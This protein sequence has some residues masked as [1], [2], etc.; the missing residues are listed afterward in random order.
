MKSIYYIPLALCFLVSCEQDSNLTT[1][2]TETPVIEA[3]LVGGQ[4][5]DTFKV[6]Q[7]VSY[8]SQDSVVTA[9]D[10]LS[11]FISDGS[12]TTTI[13]LNNIGDGIYQNLDFIIQNAQSYTMSF[14][15]NGEVIAAETYIPA[16]KE[17]AATTTTIYMDKIE[18]NGSFP[19]FG[20]LQQPDPVEL[21]WDNQEGD[22]Y[23]VVVQNIEEDPETINELIQRFTGGRRF[24]FI[25]EPQVMD[26]YA[27]QP[28]REIQQF[29]T[30]Q[31]IVFRVNPEYAAL[32]ETS[33]TTSTTISQ[34]PSNIEN[35]LGIFTG[36]ATDTVFLE[37]V[38]R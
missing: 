8:A 20:D 34:P 4:P 15:F 7:S 30:H 26:F 23:Y 16:S 18:D 14:E 3:Y 10:N 22:Y 2:T 9:L 27:I 31:I 12:N 11:I 33:G 6:T 37:V 19:N 32:Y 35:G 13:P 21:Q 25:S 29:G 17:V 1:L 28:Q 38:K 24:R 5:I 36:V